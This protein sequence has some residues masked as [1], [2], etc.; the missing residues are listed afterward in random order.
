MS[1]EK[2]E[3]IS[4]ERMESMRAIAVGKINE[5]DE[6]K[7]R[8]NTLFENAL[9][10]IYSF[11][12]EDRIRILG[13][14]VEG[15][16]VKT[17]ISPKRWAD[18]KSKESLIREVMSGV[19][20]REVEEYIKDKEDAAL[21]KQ[22]EKMRKIYQRIGSGIGVTLDTEQ[23]RRLIAAESIVESISTTSVT[24]IGAMRAIFTRALALGEEVDGVY[25]RCFRFAYPNGTPYIIPDLDDYEYIDK[26]G[27]KV[28]RSG[29]K[30]D[31][32]TKSSLK[33]QEEL[34]QLGIAFNPLILVADTDLTDVRGFSAVGKEAQNGRE[35][36]DKYKA[37]NPNL[38]IKSF[39]EMEG[40]LGVK[41][42]YRDMFYGSAA[43][44]LSNLTNDPG[45]ISRFSERSVRAYG[46]SGEFVETLKEYCGKNQSNNFSIPVSAVTL[47]RAT[48]EE[49]NSQSRSLPIER[50]T[51]GL[52]GVYTSLRIARDIAQIGVL[53]PAVSQNA[54]YVSDRSLKAVDFG[55]IG[56]KVQGKPLLP[57]IFQKYED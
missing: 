16:D 19:T 49:I 22:N 4:V 8:Q 18:E 40:E 38:N 55:Y 26:N 51:A 36:T 14:L 31:S 17:V 3:I 43:Y 39:S 57:T 56:N 46:F 20:Q 25:I 7:E 28:I 27:E 41:E 47:E 10:D 1:P 15:S 12:V 5:S 6:L 30:V 48:E 21:K 50:C 45:Y 23:T 35:F 24:N 11:P 54:I 34:E 13:G 44:L 2:K 37:E 53:I 9:N 29:S 42:A 52:V 32:W 33:L